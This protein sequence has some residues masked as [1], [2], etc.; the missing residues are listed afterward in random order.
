MNNISF[1][2]LAKAQASMM[3]EEDRRRRGE[4]GGGRKNR[5][6]S[7]KEKE[8]QE[9]NYKIQELP[10]RLPPT[11]T[12]GEK[13][14]RTSKH[15]PTI[16]STKRAVSRK[17][18]VI[19]PPAIPKPRDPRFD[20]T[21]MNKKGKREGIEKA[22]SFLTQY[23]EDEL[24]EM[25]RRLSS[26]TKK[27]KRGG[28]DDSRE[29]ESL[30]RAIRS[31]TDRM[32]SIENKQR[33]DQVRAEHKRREK[34]LIRETGKRPYYLKRSALKE[35]VL[36]QKYEGM[37]SRDRVKALERRRKKVA[38]RERRDMPMERRGVDEL[39][40]SNSTSSRKRKR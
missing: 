33:E 32:Q 27:K 31:T 6:D 37:K 19:E 35:R 20:P 15:A 21:V 26:I 2:A 28:T 23:R 30:K 34:Q 13:R 40:P 17:R 25:K 9:E 14:R 4:G 36:T 24:E 8:G 22:Y 39:L 10:K 29:V 3:G 1:G 7:N 12:D 16:Q 5:R 38:S 18:T 11:T